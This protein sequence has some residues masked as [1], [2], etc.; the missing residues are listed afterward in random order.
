MIRTPK[1]DAACEAMSVNHTSAWPKVVPVEIAAE[2]ERTLNGVLD[3]LRK[4]D[5][6]LLQ[7][8]PNCTSEYLFG[9]MQSAFNEVRLA[10]Q[11]GTAH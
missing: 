10:I 5:S 1:T 3:G 7:A 8:N 9:Q 4:V 2:L 11:S 6:I